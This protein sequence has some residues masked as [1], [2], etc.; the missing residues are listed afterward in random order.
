MRVTSVDIDA[1]S[2]GRFVAPQVTRRIAKWVATCS[3]ADVPPHVFQAARLLTLDGLGCGIFGATQ[4]WTRIVTEFVVASGGNAEATVWGTTSVVP[5]TA[6]PLA[7]GTSMHAFEYDDLHP[8]AVL[9]AGAQVLPAAFAVAEMQARRAVASEQPPIT[10]LD[11]LHAIVLGFEVG[12]RIG[13]ATG[14]GQLARGFHP[15]PNTGTFAA[16]AT[17]C[18]LL[19]LD[20]ER[21][22]HA[23]GIAGSFGGYL[24]A[25]QYGAMV[26]RVHPGH[27]SQSGLTA[28]L[29]AARGLTGTEAVLEAPYG[30]FA[31]TFA[32]AGG[33]ELEDT[34]AGLG[35]RWEIPAFSIKYYPC[36]GSNHTSLDAWWTILRQHPGITTDQ[37]HRI[38]VHCST[39]TADHVGWPYKPGSVTTAQMN[40]AYCLAAAVVDGRFTVDQV[41]TD[42]L[43]DPAIL[44]LVDRIHIRADPT[45]DD[46][47]RDRRHHIR[48]TVTTRDGTTIEADCE[49]PKGSVDNPLAESEV[50]DKFRDLAG[51]VLAGDAVPE[52]E[53]RILALGSQTPLDTLALSALLATGAAPQPK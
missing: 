23:L 45:I 51:R 22:E 46:L 39:L 8:R 49:H 24:M 18:R 33:P 31:T 52:L 20:A 25:A 4:P 36:C 47:G 13:L 16:A 35:E 30:G 38:D 37:I 27:A 48:L 6:A 50:I 32:D 19:R 29:L 12:A 7:N 14:T 34:T 9:H 3:P 11:L 5:A 41:D 15:S 28:A 1:E 42:R 53:R 43:A 21:T 40:L 17:A 44:S 10:E 2:G 26:K